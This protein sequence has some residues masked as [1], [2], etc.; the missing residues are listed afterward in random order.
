M[1]LV[2]IL[3][4]C[5]KTLGKRCQTLDCS[6]YLVEKYLMSSGVGRKKFVLIDLSE[7]MMMADDDE[8]EDEVQEMIMENGHMMA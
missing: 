8:D 3:L 5:H 6:P 1:A 7:K 4:S 2:L